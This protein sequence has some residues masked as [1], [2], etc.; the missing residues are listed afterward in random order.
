MMTRVT[1]SST[2]AAK[3]KKEN[4]DKEQENVQNCAICLNCVEINLLASLDACSHKFCLK[5]I[6]EWSK[7]RTFMT[8]INVK[9][10][11]LKIY[12]FV[13]FPKD[14][15]YVSNR[16]NSLQQHF[17]QIEKKK[18]ESSEKNQSSTQKQHWRGTKSNFGYL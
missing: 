1:R 12:P 8:A 9:V 3:L 13:N 6:Q 14:E 2:L 15:Q 17:S 10:N 4:K 16:S 11:R 5:C 7:V 18:L